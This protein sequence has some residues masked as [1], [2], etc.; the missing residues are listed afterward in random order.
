MVSYVGVLSSIL[1][2]LIPT[3]AHAQQAAPPFEQAAPPSDQRLTPCFEIYTNP[4]A[5][6]AGSFLLNKCTGQTWIAVGTAPTRWY[7][8]TTTKEEFNPPQP[9]R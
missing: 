1:L 5:G 3:L 7:P 6:P 9:P 8:V 4:A 2:L